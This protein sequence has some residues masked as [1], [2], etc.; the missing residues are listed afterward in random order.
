MPCDRRLKRGQ[1]IQM[2]AAEIRRVVELA[3]RGLS[4]GKVKAKVGP[5]GAI[6]FV[7]LTDA[8]RDGVTDSC[9]YRRLLTSGSALALQAIAAAEALAGRSVDRQL[10]AQGAH[11]HDGGA[12]WHNHK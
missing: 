3:A 8:E 9:M 1:T 7:G 4:S 6:A 11:S 10:V 5:Q 2:R 12:T